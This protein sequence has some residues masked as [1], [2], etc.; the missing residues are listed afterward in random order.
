MSTIEKT[1]D[2]LEAKVNQL[3]NSWN[4]FTMGIM[5]STIVK[6]AV[7]GLRMILDAINALTGKTGT[8]RATI[9]KTIFAFEGFKAVRNVIFALTD[10]VAAVGIQGLFGLPGKGG[11]SFKDVFKGNLKRNFG[12]SYGGEQAAIDKIKI[13]IN[14]RIIKTVITLIMIILK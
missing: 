7:D 11:K 10:T 1:M 5:N 4:N 8:L 13:K 14:E 12:A 9:L 3:T 6:G 2:S